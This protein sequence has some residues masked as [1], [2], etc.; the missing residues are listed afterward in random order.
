MQLWDKFNEIR[1]IDQTVLWLNCDT[2]ALC[3]Y[4]NN[5]CRNYLKNNANNELG[6]WD[7]E[8]YEAGYFRGLKNYC[9][10]DKVVFNGINRSLDTVIKDSIIRITK[11]YEKGLIINNK[12]VPYDI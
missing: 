5:E 7:F 9:L 10:D 4:V 12:V 8:E 2:D 6:G 1:S 11:V 3:V